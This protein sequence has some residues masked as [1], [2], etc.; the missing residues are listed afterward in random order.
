MNFL[1]HED[2]GLSDEINMTP[3]IDIVFLLLIFF[4]VSTTFVES[5]GITVNLPKASTAPSQ[6]QSTDISINI[7]RQGEI[8]YEN[9]KILIEELPSLIKSKASDLAS[10]LFIVRADKAAEHGQVV[11]VLD[12]AKR[13]GVKR[14]AVATA[15]SGSS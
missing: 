7:S 13:T 5:H 2:D 8:Y 4:M 1:E 9:R 14:I 15:P 12:A 6:A 10:T 3:L 11:K